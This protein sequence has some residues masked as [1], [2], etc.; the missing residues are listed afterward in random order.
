MLTSFHR[1][2]RR[3]SSVHCSQHS[4]QF[5]TVQCGAVQVDASVR[6]LFFP[7]PSTESMAIRECYHLIVHYAFV[8]NHHAF[9]IINI[10]SQRRRL[11]LFNKL[12]YVKYLEKDVFQ[13]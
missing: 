12:G 11:A 8:A 9:W 2:A 4:V 3:D 10:K 13:I 1:I 5:S 6:E 7:R